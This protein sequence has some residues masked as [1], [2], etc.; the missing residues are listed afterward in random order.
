M[1][2]GSDQ[3]LLPVG[4]HGRQVKVDNEQAD[5]PL[6][7]GHPIDRHITFIFTERYYAT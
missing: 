2:N 6:L 1:F 4:V 3:L 5:L 7:L